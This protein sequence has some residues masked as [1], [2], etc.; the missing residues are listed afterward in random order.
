M[1]FTAICNGVKK[2]DNLGWV[3]FA[4]ISHWDLKL[5]PFNRHL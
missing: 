4:L 2:K 3:M 1:D 5:E